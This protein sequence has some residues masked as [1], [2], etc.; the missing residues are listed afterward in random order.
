MRWK[1]KVEPV[2]VIFKT[3]PNKFLINYWFVA[4]NIA[5]RTGDGQMPKRLTDKAIERFKDKRK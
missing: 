5:I 4:Y 2:L 1:K 3:N